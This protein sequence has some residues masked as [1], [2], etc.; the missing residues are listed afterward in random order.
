MDNQREYVILR[1]HLKQ[2]C[3][4]QRRAT[5]SK[6]LERKRTQSLVQVGHAAG[7][8]IL[9]PE[10]NADGREH[11]LHRHAISLHDSRAQ[12][13]VTIDKSGQRV[14]QR[15]RSQFSAQAHIP[16]QV[17]DRITGLQT[18]E[19]PDPLLHIRCGNQAGRN[20]VPTGQVQRP[21]IQVF[22]G[23]KSRDASH[24]RPFKYCTQRQLRL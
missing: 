21:L 7:R 8:R 18:I 11:F 12:R 5:Q 1:P 23:H 3:P 15:R 20:P 2:G 9:D 17:V 14:P 16:G 6:R 4:K 19:N 13:F 24:G 22:V 10:R